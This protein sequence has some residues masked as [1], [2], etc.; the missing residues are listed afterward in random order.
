[1]LCSSVSEVNLPLCSVS[2]KSPSSVTS[3][4]F[5]SLLNKI[6]PKQIV[7]GELTVISFFQYCLFLLLKRDYQLNVTSSDVK[8]EMKKQFKQMKDLI[9]F[10]ENEIIKEEKNVFTCAVDVMNV[11]ITVAKVHDKQMEIKMK[12][13]SSKKCGLDKVIH[14]FKNYYS[15]KILVQSKKELNKQCNC[16]CLQ[17]KS[18][19]S[20]LGIGTDL[21]PY[22]SDYDANLF[23]HTKRKIKNNL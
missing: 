20:V 17:N 19:L 4:P 14:Y 16:V 3:E 10:F 9:L 22:P 23:L 7:S 18:Y 12:N 11:M 21:G 2:S 5:L 8:D 1:M 13:G 6:L 15:Q